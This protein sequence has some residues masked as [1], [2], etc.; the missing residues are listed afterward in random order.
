MARKR[1][2]VVRLTAKQRHAL[3]RLAGSGRRSARAIPRAR[4][5]RMAD[6]A[7]TLANWRR[8]EV[9]ARGTKR[10]FA[11]FIKNLVDGRYADVEKVV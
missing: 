11:R 7:E 5:L 3:G 1:E 6:A 10:D 9:T 4:I 8:P 2:C